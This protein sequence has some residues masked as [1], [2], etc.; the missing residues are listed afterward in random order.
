M[1][2][3]ERSAIANEKDEK[4]KSDDVEVGRENESEPSATGMQLLHDAV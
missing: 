4:R 2:T 3:V 1:D